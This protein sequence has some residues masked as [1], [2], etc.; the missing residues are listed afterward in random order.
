VRDTDK[1]YRSIASHFGANAYH[2]Q[3]LTYGDDA[4]APVGHEA[5]YKEVYEAHNRAVSEYFSGRPQ[6]LLVMEL[7]KGDG[8]A[9]LGAFLNVPVPDGPFVRTNTSTQRASFLQRVR[10]KLHRMGLPVGTM[11]G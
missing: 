2:I 4:P 7:E 9:K 11:D 1:W 6:D 10:K 3:Q 5:R 8:W